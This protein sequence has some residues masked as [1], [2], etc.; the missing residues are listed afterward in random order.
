[1]PSIRFLV[2][3]WLLTHLLIKRETLVASFTLWGEG[4]SKSLES[5]L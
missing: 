3:L 1:M 5:E 2:E 4:L